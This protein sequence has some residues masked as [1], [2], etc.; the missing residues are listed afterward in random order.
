[1]KI[2]GEFVSWTANKELYKKGIDVVEIDITPEELARQLTTQQIKEL[3][4][5]KPEG[6]VQPKP[7]QEY[8]ECVSTIEQFVKA[9]VWLAFCPNCG[10]HKPLK[11]EC[12]PK[13]KRIEK[14][15]EYDWDKWH[16]KKCV[17]DRKK[18]NEIVLNH[19]ALCAVVE[20]LIKQIN[21]LTRGKE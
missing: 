13:P 5:C 3:V 10:K 18:I 17:E 4:D 19:K 8:C 14:L 21:H 20:E 12:E 15:E 7:T 16:T 11:K 9:G 2:K 6:S 1:M